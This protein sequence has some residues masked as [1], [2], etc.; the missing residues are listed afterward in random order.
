MKNE[1]NRFIYIGLKRR[2]RLLNTMFSDLEGREGIAVI[3]SMFPFSCQLIDLMGDGATRFFDRK[4]FQYGMYLFQRIYNPLKK[5]GFEESGSFLIFTNFSARAMSVPYI[6][7]ILKTHP[8][9]VPVMLFLDQQEIFTAVYARKLVEKM[10]EFLCLTFDPG[11]ARRLGY[12]HT[13]SV[14]SKTRLPAV[15]TDCDLYVSFAGPGRLQRV[16]QIGRSLRLRG[17]SCRIVYVGKIPD[18]LD[19][20]LREE[21]ENCRERMTYETVLADM[22]RANCLLEFVR[23]TQS[24]VTVRYYEAV[25]Y[26]KKLLTTNKNVVN[27]PFYDA[28][29]M[30]V[31]EKPEDIDPDWVSRRE[32]VDYG[33]DGRFSPLHLLEEI[34]EGRPDREKST[35][36]SD[37]I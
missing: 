6:R 29:Y 20:E 13:M 8:S 32:P 23:D 22:N 21:F 14:Y 15:K 10:P 27:L 11:D 35:S 1:K 5:I 16:A 30:R 7:H 37:G 4:W 24:G 19:Q 9:C 28:R 36:G 33:Y 26:Q 2:D 3:G 25:C 18:S 31:F 34:G 12:R 17:V